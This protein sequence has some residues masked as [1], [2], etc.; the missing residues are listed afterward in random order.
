MWQII[1]EWVFSACSVCMCDTDAEMISIA[2]ELCSIGI[3]TCTSLLP[4][5]AKIVLKKILA[6]VT[7]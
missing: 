5:A 7:A 3:I 4:L 6:V 2:S 1:Y